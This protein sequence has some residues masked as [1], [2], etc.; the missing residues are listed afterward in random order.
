M[1]YIAL[2][3]ANS[4]QFLVPVPGRRDFSFVVHGGLY[5]PQRTVE[6]GLNIEMEAGINI[7][8]FAEILL[9]EFSK[10]HEHDQDH[11]RGRG[12]KSVHLR[13]V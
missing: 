2:Q 1:S 4:R 5:T 3:C 12:R 10:F 11:G 8:I 13:V 6:G 7:E 9:Y